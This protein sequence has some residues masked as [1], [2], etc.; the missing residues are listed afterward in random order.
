MIFRNW[1]PIE[2]RYFEKKS[3]AHGLIEQSLFLRSKS[4]NIFTCMVVQ[5][6]FYYFQSTKMSQ[7]PPPTECHILGSGSLKG[8]FYNVNKCDS[9]MAAPQY[10]RKI[11]CA[12]SLITSTSTSTSILSRIHKSRYISRGLLDGHAHARRAGSSVL[13]VRIYRRRVRLCK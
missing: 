9:I 2:P 10:E 7:R 5:E 12:C 6:M 3:T 8:T 11:Q 1:Q 4:L 13:V